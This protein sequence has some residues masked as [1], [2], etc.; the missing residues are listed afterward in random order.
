L[1]RPILE[2]VRHHAIAVVALVCSILAMAGS[3]YAA[4]TISGSQIANHT[5]APTKFDPKFINGSVKAWAVVDPAGHVAAGAGGPQVFTGSGD[6][7]IPGLYDIKWRVT[8]P[9]RCATVASIDWHLSPRTYSL[10]PNGTPLPAGFAVASTVG[11]PRNRNRGAQTV[12]ET[13]SQSGQLTP[14]AFDISVIC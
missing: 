8:M 5:I 13:F 3:S 7:G 10:P 14:L 11:F 12:V 9:G 4:F 2:F 6:T 1:T